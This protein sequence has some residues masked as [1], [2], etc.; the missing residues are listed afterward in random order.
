MIATLVIFLTAL[1]F[2]ANMSSAQSFIAQAHESQTINILQSFS[3]SFFTFDINSNPMIR[4]LR[5]V[6]KPFSELSHEKIFSHEKI[7]SNKEM[8][9]LKKVDQ[10][11]CNEKME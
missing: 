4:N 2:I 5:G 7:S 6:E 11:I 8:E 1:P 9:T 10:I 3:S